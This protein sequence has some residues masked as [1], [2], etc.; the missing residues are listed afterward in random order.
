MPININ[1]D[2]NELREDRRKRKLR[3]IAAKIGLL[4]IHETPFGATTYEQSPTG[5]YECRVCRKQVSE[6]SGWVI[7]RRKE[8][9]MPGYHTRRQVRRCWK[10]IRRLERRRQ[11]L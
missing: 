7:T 10:K 9:G 2:V 1:L 8:R 4:C 11:R 5:H 6:E 3:R